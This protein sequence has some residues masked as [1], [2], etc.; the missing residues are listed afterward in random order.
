MCINKEKTPREV[1]PF[2]FLARWK[3]TN[4]FFCN[5]KVMVKEWS[6]NTESFKDILFP[7]CSCPGDWKPLKCGGVYPA[8]LWE[9]FSCHSCFGLL[10]SSLLFST[11]LKYLKSSCLP[12]LFFGS[13]KMEQSCTDGSSDHTSCILSAL[14]YVLLSAEVG[15]FSPCFISPFYFLYFYGSVVIIGWFWRGLLSF[16]FSIFFGKIWVK[17]PWE[18][19]PVVWSNLPRIPSS[20]PCS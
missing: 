3:Q 15:V 20:P 2:A 1:L 19:T 9:P 11:Q 17:Y 8:L 6:V 16:S 4:L 5:L 13:W 12:H 10:C 14:K 18:K 7:P